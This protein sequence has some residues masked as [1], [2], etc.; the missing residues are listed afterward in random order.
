MIHK[1]D[2]GFRTLLEQSKP[3][4]TKQEQELGRVIRDSDN[5]EEVAEAKTALVMA[6]LRYLV[7]V[8]TTEYYIKPP[9]ELQ[10]VVNSGIEGFYEAAARY[11]PDRGFN[12]TT[13]AKYWAKQKINAYIQTMST[14]AYVP[15]GTIYQV[16]I[17]RQTAA[18]LMQ[19]EGH[20][21]DIWELADRMGLESDKLNAASNAQHYSDYNEQETDHPFGLDLSDPEDPCTDAMEPKLMKA[22]SRLP[23]RE[24]DIICR[25][26]GLKCPRHTLREIGIFHLLSRERVRQITWKVLER[27]KRALDTPEPPPIPIL[28]SCLS[29]TGCSMKPSISFASSRCSYPQSSGERVFSCIRPPFSIY[30]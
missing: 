9:L 30:L 8:C 13:Y 6:N 3:L 27:L 20:E 16:E 18:E 22:I 26:F 12:F 25:R 2:P 17:L 19:I 5:P 14:I 24:R 28:Q 11:D 15:A 1:L 29:S 4:T 23:D 21:I 10:D 7:T